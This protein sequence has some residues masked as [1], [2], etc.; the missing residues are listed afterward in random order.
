MMLELPGLVALYKE[1]LQIQ[2][3]H[4]TRFGFCCYLILPVREWV[5]SR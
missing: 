2:L 4:D 3:I 5:S 1:S